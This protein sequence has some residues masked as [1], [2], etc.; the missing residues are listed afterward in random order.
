MRRRLVYALTTIVLAGAAQ[1]ARAA[2]PA[3]GKSWLPSWMAFGKKETKPAEPA[4]KPP[5]I[6]PA[7]EK[8][9]WLRR[10]AVC[11]RLRAVAVQT[12]DEELARKADALDQRAWEIYRARTAQAAGGSRGV[13][14]LVLDRHLGAD[15]RLPAR[16]PAAGNASRA[17][18]LNR[19][20]AREE[21]P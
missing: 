15:A 13:D 17:L 20:T 5:S 21:Q 16:G 2:E 9:E 10:V 18:G 3:A 8:A 4:A 19:T 11:D 6:S 7:K 1:T 12:N 14:E